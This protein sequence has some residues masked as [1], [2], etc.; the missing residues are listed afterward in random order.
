MNNLGSDLF[1]NSPLPPTPVGDA[2]S[3]YDLDPV[4][5]AFG[6]QI[7]Q[8]A[9]KKN[10][11]AQYLARFLGG[12]TPEDIDAEEEGAAAFDE[13]T[14]LAQ[15]T[16]HWDDEKFNK[17]LFEIQRTR[18]NRPDAPLIPNVEPPNL[19]QGIAGAI[20]AF[21]FPNRAFEIAGAP[22]RAQEEARD[23]AYK[24]Q[25]IQY[26]NQSADWETELQNKQETFRLESERENR[27]ADEFYRTNNAQIKA[28]EVKQKQISDR[29]NTAY[30]NY[31]RV[32]GD[33]DSDGTSLLLAAR[34]LS[35][36]AK[37]AGLPD[38]VDLESEKKS[39]NE[40]DKTLQ[41]KRQNIESQIQS[42]TNR[43]TILQKQ[44]ERGLIT[45]D[46]KDQ[47]LSWQ[48]EFKPDELR[49]LQ[50]QAD[51]AEST[52]KWADRKA[53]ADIQK[54]LSATAVAE[55]NLALAWRKYQFPVESKG[56][57]SEETLR[58]RTNAVIT[59]LKAENQ[60]LEAK[61][62]QAGFDPVA[63]Q[64]LTQKLGE[65]KKRIE[66]L[67]QGIIKTDGTMGTMQ[68]PGSVSG[69]L[70]KGADGV[71]RPSPKGNGG[72]PSNTPGQANRSQ[73]R[74]QMLA[75]RGTLSKIATLKESALQTF[76]FLKGN[77]GQYGPGSIPTSLHNSGQAL[78][79][80]EGGGARL[81]KAQGDSIV[82]W[83]QENHKDVK[84]IIWDGRI[85]TPSK[86]WHK[87][88]GPNDHKGHVHVDYGR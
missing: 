21:A 35:E 39:A 17:L 77:I 15:Q 66:E 78:D 6:R 51:L 54:V 16:Y 72:V 5:I 81:T 87:Y 11:S 74:S 2:P 45:Q 1:P 24:N 79:F 53:A 76:P 14:K 85:W 38:P 67:R 63:V 32:K 50:A 3:V 44:F 60:E 4:E 12:Q 10:R 19:A 57:V 62:K 46:L 69:G 43:D 20:G 58:T 73:S 88:T 65:N 48:I 33:P 75:G 27:K 7:A 64:S 22:F 31:L 23:L 29:F 84:T 70:V 18:A 30:A 37:A 40:R 52:A 86:G 42:R 80:G 26:Q 83:L 8:K 56:E 82:K 13:V 71:Y 49:R 41:I 61:I 59:A 34:Q 28:L 9:K 25:Q 47:L 55:G 36:T 68:P